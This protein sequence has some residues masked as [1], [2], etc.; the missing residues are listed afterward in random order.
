[1]PTPTP[2]STADVPQ[3]AGNGDGAITRL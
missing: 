3:A 2:E 1:L